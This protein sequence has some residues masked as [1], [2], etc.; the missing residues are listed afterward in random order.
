MIRLREANHKQIRE[1]KV[2]KAFVE[3]W[4]KTHSFA[5]LKNRKE[6]MALVNV[7]LDHFC[8]YISAY[9]ERDVE[10]IIESSIRHVAICKVAVEMLADPEEAYKYEGLY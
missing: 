6:T 8:E 3:D 7:I 1:L 4:Q 2:R 5:T 10:K 9:E